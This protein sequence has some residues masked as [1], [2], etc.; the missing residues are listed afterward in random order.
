VIKFAINAINYKKIEEMALLAGK[1]GAGELQL[2]QL[3]P[4]PENLSAGLTLAPDKWEEVQAEVLRLANLLKINLIFSAGT[5]VDDAFPIC[6]HLG[7]TEYYVDSRGWLCLC[8]MLGGIAGRDSRKKEKDRIAD[9][10]KTSFIDAHRK[11]M[12]LINWFNEKR[13]D[14]IEKG[15]MSELLHYQCLACAFYFGKLD[16]LKDFPD[17]AWAKMLKQA[18][19]RAR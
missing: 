19:G 9:L 15:L 5:F 17:S 4:T 14:R 16:W 12:A 1:L 8:C 3:Y 13:L 11:L 10:S 2:A 18:K 6:A 7:M